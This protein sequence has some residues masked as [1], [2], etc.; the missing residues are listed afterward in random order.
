MSVSHFHFQFCGFLVLPC[1]CD[2]HDYVLYDDVDYWDLLDDVHQD[3]VHDDD[4]DD[5]AQVVYLQEEDWWKPTP[6]RVTPIP[7][8]PENLHSDFSNELVC[9]LVSAQY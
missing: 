2:V 6:A 4:H 3:A 9:W 1:V 7:T 8:N 5:D